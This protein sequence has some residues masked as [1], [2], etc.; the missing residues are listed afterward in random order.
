MDHQQGGAGGGV[1]DGVAPVHDTVG[2][3]SLAQGVGAEPEVKK[4]CQW[5]DLMGN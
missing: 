2:N 1:V 4:G 5:P 3:A